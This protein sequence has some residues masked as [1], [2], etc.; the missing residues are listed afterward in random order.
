MKRRIFLLILLFSISFVH[1][2]KKEIKVWAM[3][4]AGFVAGAL[5]PAVDFRITTGIRWQKWDFGAGISFDEYKQPSYP[6]YIQARRNIQYR[7][8]HPFVFGSIG[9]NYKSGSDTVFTWFG[10]KVNIYHG[11]FFVEAG[12]GLIFK[13]RK[14]ERLFVSLYQTYKRSSATS[15]EF[16]WAGPGSTMTVPSTEI[17]RMNRVGI[18]VGW[19]LG[20]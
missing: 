9:Y 10:N 18:R 5:N 20:D 3:P 13:I 7:K 17:F 11:G 12:M 4:E 16:R 19:K 15:Q 14:K 6:L 2:Q 1:A 8:L